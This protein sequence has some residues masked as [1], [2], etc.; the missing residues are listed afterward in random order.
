MVEC[1]RLLAAPSAEVTPAAGKG[2]LCRDGS[3]ASQ[4]VLDTDHVGKNATPRHPCASSA[5]TSEQPCAEASLFR[6]RRSCEQ[7]CEVAELEHVSTDNRGSGHATLGSGESGSERLLQRVLQ[8]AESL[9]RLQTELFTLTMARIAEGFVR[10]CSAPQ[11]WGTERRLGDGK[12]PSQ[13]L[14]NKTI[15]VEKAAPILVSSPA[16]LPG[17]VHAANELQ[18]N[19]DALRQETRSPPDSLESSLP[20]RV[21][22]LSSP[23]SPL[24][25]PQPAALDD[26]LDDSR[27]T[28]GDSGETT[29]GDSGDSAASFSSSRSRRTPAS[30]FLQ[31]CIALR[32]PRT[33]SPLTKLTARQDFA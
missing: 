2:E 11:P 4:G 22:S 24:C 7:Q 12:P 3:S 29:T 13:V 16:G 31:T 21:S 17:T 5:L 10:E 18:S 25:A 20:A 32:I 1:G 15:A 9:D 6:M 27:E 30:S 28:A 8:R 33:S 14:W 19:D 26:T 23:R